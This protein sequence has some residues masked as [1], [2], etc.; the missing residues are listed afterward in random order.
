MILI[1]RFWNLCIKW[2]ILYFILYKISV[3][4]MSLSTFILNYLELAEPSILVLGIEPLLSFQLAIRGEVTNTCC[5]CGLNPCWE[6]WLFIWCKKVFLF[7]FLFL[8]RFY[9]FERDRDTDRDSK[10]AQVGRRG[11]SRL[12]TEQKQASYW[13]GSPA[14]GL[15][16]RTQGSWPELKAATQPPRCPPKVVFIIAQG[17]DPWAERAA[18]SLL[19]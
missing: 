7:I 2:I 17:Q 12:P 5:E 6:A 3:V 14:W 16:P 1:I 19:F 9:L 18:E 10:R 4:Q 13:A 11:R 8:W 15:H